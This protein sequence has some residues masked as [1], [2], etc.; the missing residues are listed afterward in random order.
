MHTISFTGTRDVTRYEEAYIG[1]VVVA[2]KADRFVSG[3]AQ[4]VDTSAILQAWGY[5]AGERGAEARLVVPEGCAYNVRLVN[6]FRGRQ[7]VAIEF[8]YGGYMK[9]NDRLVELADTL[10]AF[11][12]T[13]QEVLR[14]GTWATIRRARKA[15]I[16]VEL[17]PLEEA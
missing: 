10:V 13:R 5:H 9:R 14:S 17:Y 7:D 12:R 15:G 16:P 11:P 3:A 6:Y 2:L 8:V 1:D 4:G